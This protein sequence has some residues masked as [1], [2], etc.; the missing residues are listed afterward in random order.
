MNAP[1]DGHFKNPIAGRGVSTLYSMLILRLS[2]FAETV[3]FE[4]YFGPSQAKLK[5]DKGVRQAQSVRRRPSVG[6]D[7]GQPHHARTECAGANGA[8]NDPDQRV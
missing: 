1:I 6:Q 3:V 5:Y 2:G 8:T 7:G 4:T